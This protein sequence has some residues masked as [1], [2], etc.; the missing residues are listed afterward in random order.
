MDICWTFWGSH[1]CDL[2]AQ[3]EGDHVCG[4]NDG[5]GPYVCSK[6]RPVGEWTPQHYSLGNISCPAEVL[7]SYDGAEWTPGWTLFN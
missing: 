5:D 3:H 4:A 1:G 6:A 7:F 2:P